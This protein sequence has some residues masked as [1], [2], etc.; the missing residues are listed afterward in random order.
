[1]KNVE[2]AIN[3]MLILVIFAV[4][5]KFVL[6]PVKNKIVEKSE[7][8]KV[9]DIADGIDL[10]DFNIIEKEEIEYEESENLYTDYLG[11]IENELKGIEF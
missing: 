5:V 2:K 9:T 7:Q 1:M 10:N 4:F 3:F 6:V 11:D 8:V